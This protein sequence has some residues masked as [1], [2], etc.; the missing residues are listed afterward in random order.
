M[1]AKD[2]NCIFVANCFYTVPDPVTP[3]TGMGETIC[4][5]SEKNIKKRDFTKVSKKNEVF[6]P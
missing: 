4:T 2:E 1:K 3:P 6:N 5:D